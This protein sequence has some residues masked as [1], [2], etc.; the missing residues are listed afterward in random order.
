LAI[1]AEHRRRL[2]ALRPVGR[3]PG[4]LKCSPDSR[5][6]RPPT[7][8]DEVFDPFAVV[9][10][11]AKPAARHQQQQQRLTPRQR[12]PAAQPPWGRDMLDLLGGRGRVPGQPAVNPPGSGDAVRRGQP[13]V[14]PPQS[15]DLLDY[16]EQPP[17]PARRPPDG[18]TYDPFAG[19]A[20]QPAAMQPGQPAVRQAAP[21]QGKRWVD[22]QR[23]TYSA[24]AEEGR[25]HSRSSRVDH[26]SRL[27]IS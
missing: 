12:Q 26:L 15:Y 6:R 11:P 9:T 4:G 23:A 17:Q 21:A 2:A 16:S 14:N 24:V 1:H 10:A 22:R 18:A 20:A 8:N 19:M 25:R 3:P 27:M 5:R 7:P 13:V